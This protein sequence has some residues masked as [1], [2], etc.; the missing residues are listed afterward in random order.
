M[1]LHLNL[2][3]IIILYSSIVLSAN[4]IFG[5]EVNIYVNQS[6][7]TAPY[8][9]YTNQQIPEGFIPELLQNIAGDEIS[10]NY[11]SDT[12]QLHKGGLVY[13]GITRDEVPGD[14]HFIKLPHSLVYYVFARKGSTMVSFNGL[15]SKKII[16]VKGD[17]P[18]EML[19]ENKASY[20]F[21]VRSYKEALL[22]LSSGIN[23]YAIIPFQIGMQIIEDNKLKNIDFNIVPFLS[24]DWGI[25]VPKS[26]PSLI[27][28]FE[29]GLKDAMNNNSYKLIE[30]KWFQNDLAYHT[31]KKSINL[32]LFWVIVLIFVV[33]IVGLLGFIR[34]LMREIHESTR[35]YVSEIS[36]SNISPLSI[37]LNNPFIERL[38]S[39]APLWLMVN[40]INGNIHHISQDF[41]LEILHTEIKPQDFKVSDIFNDEITEILSSYDFKLAN[42]TSV[43]INEQL[44]FAIDGNKV[45]RWMLKYP[46][47]IQGTSD[48]MFLSLFIK[49]LIEGDS[50]LRYHSPEYLFHA[51]IDALPDSIFIKNSNGTYIGGNKAF[52]NFSGKPEVEIIGKNDLEVFGEQKAEQY[53]KSDKVVFRA[54]LIWE[55]QEW[56]TTA[57]GK[58]VRFENIKIPLRNRKNDIFGLV[59]ISHDVTNYYKNEQELAKAKEKAEESD[60]IKS[61]FLANMSHEIRTPMNSIIGFS[62]LLADQDLTIDQR[63]EII[64]MIQ[65]NGHTLIDLI[66]DI[67]DFSRIEAGQIHLKFG[68]FN[69]N[70]TLKEAYNY[71]ISK[72]NQ[73]NKEHLNITYGLG[74]IEDEFD[75]HSEP[76]RLRQVLKN[77]LNHSIR[78]STSES[79]FLGYQIVD[80]SLLL[81]IKND[82]N[83]ISDSILDNI[84][85]GKL[86][87]EF[88]FSDIEE[89]TG[90]SLIIAKNV[91]EMIGGQL[92]ADEIVPGRTDFY[93]IIPLKRAESKSN[94]QVIS[95]IAEI[96]DW[97][98]K[99]ILIAEDEETNFL[100][101]D[102]IISKTGAKIIRA[103]NG[104][105]AVDLYEEFASD[106]S[107]VLM[108]IRMPE[109]NGAEAAKRILEQYPEAIIIAQTAY[110]MPEDKEHYLK[111][112]MKSVLAKP[113]DPGELYYLCNKYL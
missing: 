83:I 14:Y 67:I 12:S 4:Y 57:N 59:G 80:N 92:F 106:I 48:L 15:L 87:F 96:S 45:L 24:F 89:S 74:A 33:I 98:G 28:R 11:T 19:Y 100:L 85:S 77:L 112:G 53:G 42:Q 93:F 70:N 109:L 94:S 43:L 20:I 102:G 47:R 52:F 111:V 76:F 10:L 7:A 55:G 46:L 90:I 38:L 9:R 63:I 72:K 99:T 95:N 79:L 29:S 73:L 54:G 69:L 101:L 65:S 44:S 97:T 51:V 50:V 31:H 16:V 66:D 1:G 49:P 58:I 22:M 32:S 30:E 68:D 21:K 23:D 3:K 27:E 62:D 110:A 75:I 82:N 34:F 25:A 91:I 6:K 17:L 61:S 108:D 26:K 36:Q 40:D 39:S 107:L 35:E 8:L 64:D 78:F 41:L 103:E 37:D 71:G 18:Y 13:G 84:K 105:M 5:S 81:Y 60:R 2:K 113:I 86:G 56:D 88:S 104:L